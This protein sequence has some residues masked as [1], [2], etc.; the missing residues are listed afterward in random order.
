ML[1]ASAEFWNFGPQIGDRG[2]DG[3]RPEVGGRLSGQARQQ[4][5]QG[6]VH[7]VQLATQRDVAQLGAGAC[8]AHLPH[9]RAWP[10]SRSLSC[11]CKGEGM[12]EPQPRERMRV[13]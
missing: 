5:H 4:V 2:R 7:L 8:A 12:K 9:I 1:P 11:S 6:A 13:R 10:C 3:G